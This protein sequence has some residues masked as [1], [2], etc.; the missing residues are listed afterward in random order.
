FALMRMIDRRVS[1]FFLVQGAVSLVAGVLAF[2]LHQGGVAF[3]L[4]LLSVHSA[5][6]GFLELYGGLRM[7]G[8]TPEARDWVAAGALTAVAAL[9]FVLG[10][11]D[12]IFA[13]GVL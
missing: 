12:P 9:V 1:V 3:L 10:P 11:L 2:A 7:R 13:V 6:T 4:Y 8:R 5:L